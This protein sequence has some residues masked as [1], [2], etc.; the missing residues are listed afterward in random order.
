[1]KRASAFNPGRKKTCR[2]LAAEIL[3]NVDKRK[4]Y[5]DLLLDRALR[6]SSLVPRDRALLTELVYGT[7]RWRGTIDWHLA[8]YLRR[9]LANTDAYL[10]N[11]LRLALYQ[12]LY[13]DKVPGYAAVDEAVK[14]A[15]VRGGRRAAG[16]VNGVL[17]KFLDRKQTPPLPTREDGCASYLSVIGSHPDWLVK[18]WLERFG[19]E[20]TEALL[21]ANNEPAPLILRS[22]RLKVSREALLEKFLAAG[23]EAAPARWSPQGI[24]VKGSAGVERLP[25]FEQGLFQ[26]QSEASQLVG[27]LLAPRPDE[28]VLD[29]CAAPGGKS[30]HIAELM[31]D[32]GEITAI[33]IS[34]R[35][36][37]KLN[38][39][40]QR[41]GLRSVLASRADI[42]MDLEE[43]WAAPYDRILV[44]SP[45]SA[46]GT[47][48][49]HP[50]AKWHKSEAD[51]VRLGKLQ[52]RLLHQ[53]SRYLKPGGALV[54][55]TCTL[56]CEEN[57]KV[58]SDFLRRHSD[59]E[60]DDASR[61]LPDDARMLVSGKFLL[62]LPHQHDTD[63]FFAARVKKKA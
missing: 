5:A 60:L 35:G 1:M 39:N 41:L 53:A 20:Q 34:A 27:F 58:V 24:R 9:P 23:L 8:V 13:L 12:I 14:D 63:G 18:R 28:R 17:R 15:K 6:G 57:E 45:C 44:D 47:L 22:N 11:L 48:R 59:F 56:M 61:Y 7:L 2:A 54:Y 4:A 33:D 52:A 30:T 16:F 40:V 21:K 37:E 32:R 55:A 62:T 31:D 50:E 29:A 3:H 49:S 19:A 10:R 46:L 43:S 25:G 51:I 38:E 36:L 42:L 26:V